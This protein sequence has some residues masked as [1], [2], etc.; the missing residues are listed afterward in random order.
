MHPSDKFLCFLELYSASD[1][2][3]SKI[4]DLSSA[5]IC[6]GCTNSQSF[7]LCMLEADF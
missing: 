5:K 3:H 4:L 7:I 2:A 1:K 6:R